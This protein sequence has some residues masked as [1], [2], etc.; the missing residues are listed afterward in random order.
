[1][2]NTNDTINKNDDLHNI[3]QIILKYELIYIFKL[4]VFILVACTIFI[5][6]KPEL[7]YS[8]TKRDIIGTSTFV[9]TTTI[10]CVLLARSIKSELK[11]MINLIHLAFCFLMF[12][13][14][15]IVFLIY[16]EFIEISFPVL[17]LCDIINILCCFSPL[18]ELAYDTILHLHNEKEN[19]Y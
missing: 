18:L 11:G 8:I 17:V 19:D 14:C 13:F 12:V 7:S 16:A 3:C 1:M 6:C 9:F 15:L 5:I 4:I 10:D 2:N